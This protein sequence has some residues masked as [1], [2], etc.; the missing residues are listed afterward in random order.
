MSSLAGW[1]GNMKIESIS[2]IKNPIGVYS[3]IYGYNLESYESFGDFFARPIRPGA[4]VIEKVNDPVKV[5]VRDGRFHPL[6]N[7]Y[8]LLTNQK[9]L[10][11]CVHTLFSKTNVQSAPLTNIC[12]HGHPL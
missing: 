10:L 5:N 9:H 2:L 8:K 3:T 1:I 11:I 12:P 4:R 6:H 7:S